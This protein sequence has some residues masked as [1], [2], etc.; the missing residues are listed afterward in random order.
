MKITKVNPKTD[1]SKILQDKTDW[2]R[3]YQ[4][5]QSSVDIDAL[6]DTENPVLKDARIKRLNDK[7]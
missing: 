5:T 6:N 2:K 3:V 4:K 1:I 7:K